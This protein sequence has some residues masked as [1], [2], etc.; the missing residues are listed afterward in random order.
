MFFSDIIPQQQQPVALF[1]LLAQPQQQLMP[2]QGE[3]KKA[4]QKKVKQS[5]PLQEQT[6]FVQ[7]QEPPVQYPIYNPVL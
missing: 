3:P 7:R 5:Q 6:N 4:K 1:D 2:M